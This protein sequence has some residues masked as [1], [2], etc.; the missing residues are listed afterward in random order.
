MSDVSEATATAQRMLGQHVC[1]S[2]VLRCL[3]A[4]GYSFY[5]AQ[6]AIARAQADL[7]AVP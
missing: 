2:A 6:A 4:Y 5:V 7:R 3:E 1:P